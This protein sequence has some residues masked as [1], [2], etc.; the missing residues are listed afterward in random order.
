MRRVLYWEFSP[1]SQKVPK[2]W[3]ELLWLAQ[4]NSG[5]WARWE[6]FPCANTQFTFGRGRRLLPCAHGWGC[7]Q[8]LYS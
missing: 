8:K 6:P 7:P 2:C 3:R 1:R 5:C 4:I